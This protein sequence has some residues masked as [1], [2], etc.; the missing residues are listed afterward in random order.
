MRIITIAIDTR[1]V[2]KI[3][4]N[5]GT[6]D[7]KDAYDRFWRDTIEKALNRNNIHTDNNNQ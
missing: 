3:I 2:S 4:N 1:I 7:P 5:Y 6:S